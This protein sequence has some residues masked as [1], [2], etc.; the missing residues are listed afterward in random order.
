[1][2]TRAPVLVIGYGNPGRGD[3]AA[4]PILVERLESALPHEGLHD[5]VDILVAFQLMIEHAEAMNDRSLVVFVDA[6]ETAA[7]PF[8]LTPI[9]AVRDRSYTSH[10]LSPEALIEVQQR[11]FGKGPGEAWLLAVPGREFGF[12]QEISSVTASCLDEAFVGLCRLVR[13][14]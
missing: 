6:S 5:R 13:G 4:G 11:A 7:P 9:A 12:G 3:D 2:T 1:M 14:Y 8:E 10:E